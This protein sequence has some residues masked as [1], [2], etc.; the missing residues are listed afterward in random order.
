MAWARDRDG[1]EEKG[2]LRLGW[3]LRITRLAAV[4]K[5]KKEPG[6]MALREGIP[7]IL[8]T[9]V[10]RG[11][12]VNRLLIEA[13]KELFLRFDLSIFI[14]RIRFLLVELTHLG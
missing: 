11:N 12:G 10:R 5:S 2:W 1:L 6:R 4:R 8:R 14:R 9:L 3:P 7:V 13:A